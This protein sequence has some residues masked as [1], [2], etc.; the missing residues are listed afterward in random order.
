MECPLVD[1]QYELPDFR[2]GSITASGHLQSLA[3]VSLRVV[4]FCTFRADENNFHRPL[5]ALTG[6]S[7]LPIPVVQTP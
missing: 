4:R 5:E 3:N 2:F 1:R 6:P 7:D